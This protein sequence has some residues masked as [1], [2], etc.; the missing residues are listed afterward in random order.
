MI[1]SLSIKDFNYNLPDEKIAKYP[2]TERDSSKLLTFIDHHISE[3]VFKELPEMLP[4]NTMLVFNNTKVIR[5][6]M[7]FEKSTGARIEIFCLEPTG[8]TEI[9]TVFT[10][11][12]KSRWNC[13]IGNLK[14]WKTG[15][16]IKTI[17]INGQP[18]CIKAERLESTTDSHVIEFS[19]EEDV[20]F[21]E[22]L[23][24]AG[25]TPIPPYLNRDSEEIDTER[26]QTVY[27]QHKGSVAA[28][29]AGLH[30]TPEVLKS[31]ENKGIKTTYLTLHVGAGTFKPVK[32][33]TIE[34]HDMHVEH[35]TIETSAL[36]A[37]IDHEGALIAVGTTSVRT[38]ESLYWIG[39]KLHNG[40][41]SL[42]VNQ[43]DPYQ[44]VSTLTYK[45][46]LTCILQFI[47][48]NKLSHLSARTG[49]MIAPGYQFKAIRGLVTNFHQPQS[50]L[51]LLLSALIGD[52]WRMIYDYALNHNFRF[53]SYGDSSLIMP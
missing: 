52:E 19:W 44:I 6:R 13:I 38:M 17:K 28:P 5:A 32:S 47:E 53:L 24:E 4:A 23:E 33:E 45:E 41:Q 7:E 40:D 35:F 3:K 26:Y 22:I 1:P 20:T 27:S 9:Q 42:L 49:I 15:E 11:K 50:T 8:E 10:T 30:F 18:I 14:K 29:T 48:K 16:L 37:L 21:G 25:N 43:W 31:L 36:K 39:T 12:G 51:L 34:G 46:A 2:L